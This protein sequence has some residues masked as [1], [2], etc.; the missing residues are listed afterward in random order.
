MCFFGKRKKILAKQEELI[1]QNE[2]LR[3][4][5]TTLKE[6]MLGTVQ[7]S[8]EAVL[9]GVRNNLDA[10]LVNVK[11]VLESNEVRLGELKSE[12]SRSL[13]EI[14]E[15]ND[16]R[17]NEIR[18]DNEKRLGEIRLLVEEKVTGIINE[19]V[20]VTFSAI[21]ERLDA[22][23]KGLGEMQNLAGSVT[24]LKKILGNVKTRGVYGET[25]L[26]N[27]LS[28]ILTPEQYK[29]QFSLASRADPEGRKTV[30]FVIFL[31]GKGDGEKVYLPIDAKFPTEDYQRLVAA[32]E[33]GDANEVAVNQKALL[34]AVS[35]QAKRIRD[36]YIVPPKT[37]DF[38]LMFLP[39]EGLYAEITRAPGMVEELKNKYNVIPVGPTTLTALLSS[40]QIGFKTLAVQKS[41]KEIYDVFVRFKKE[42]TQYMDAIG[43]AINQVGTVGKT[44]EEANK[45]CT[46][47]MTSVNKVENLMPS[48]SSED[49]A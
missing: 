41:S 22:V 3:R 16:K 26:N 10:V 20:G 24:D 31:P 28:N 21:N 18:V 46:N 38:A 15:N 13:G 23:N 32:S 45:R 39:V 34:N 43:K 42:L 25:S 44:L 33:K 4:E 11:T 35:A 29:A 6:V 9:S 2:E 40:L 12:L 8:N 47:M 7:T 49:E 19:R 5:I 17:L 27:L 30:D 14:R 1:K 37:V 48:D 36:S